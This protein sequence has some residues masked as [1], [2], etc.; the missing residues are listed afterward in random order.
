[1][2]ILTNKIFR[3]TKQEHRKRIKHTIWH[4]ITEAGSKQMRKQS[5]SFA[6]RQVNRQ[7]F[8]LSPQKNGRK[9]E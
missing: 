1:M 2:L 8:L 7:R 3:A 5:S 9:V 4:A 6:N